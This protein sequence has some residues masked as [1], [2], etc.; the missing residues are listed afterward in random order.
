[1]YFAV[2]DVFGPVMI[3][4]SRPSRQASAVEAAPDFVTSCWPWIQRP[5]SLETKFI[6]NGA[7]LEGQHSHQVAAKHWGDS[8]TFLFCLCCWYLVNICT[9]GCLW[10]GKVFA[11][12]RRYDNIKYRLKNENVALVVTIMVNFTVQGCVEHFACQHDIC[13]CVIKAPSQA[14]N[15]HRGI[16]GSHQITCSQKADIWYME[17]WLHCTVFC[18][19]LLSIVVIHAVDTCL[20]HSSKPF[21]LIWPLVQ[22]TDTVWEYNIFC[23]PY[24]RDFNQAFENKKENCIPAFQNYLSTNLK[25]CF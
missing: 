14:Y 3:P 11:P 24:R 4:Y 8:T 25:Q 21:D 2:D 10:Y 18:W 23:I 16:L 9:G 1:M 5:H 15:S 17:K 7:C 22:V 13:V 19:V 12:M 6:W 20:L